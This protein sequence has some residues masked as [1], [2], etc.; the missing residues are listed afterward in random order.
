MSADPVKEAKAKL[1][2]NK[3]RGFVIKQ[4]EE[5]FST[6][7]SG[8]SENYIKDPHSAAVDKHYQGFLRRHVGCAVA[9]DVRYKRLDDDFY[10]CFNS[11]QA[12]RFPNKLA[13]KLA[14]SYGERQAMLG[15]I[16]VVQLKPDL[17]VSRVCLGTIDELHRRL[18]TVD[19]KGDE[20]ENWYKDISRRHGTADEEGHIIYIPFRGA[21]GSGNG[22]GQILSV[23]CKG[24]QGIADECLELFRKGGATKKDFKEDS[25]DEEEE[26]GMDAELE[27]V[28]NAADAQMRETF[29]G[30]GMKLFYH[31]GGMNFVVV[32][33][34]R[35]SQAQKQ[36]GLNETAA[37]YVY[38]KF[39]LDAMLRLLSKLRG[40]VLIFKPRHWHLE[41]ECG[42]LSLDEG[43]HVP[44]LEA[45][46]RGL[47]EA[48]EEIQAVLAQQD[49]GTCLS[50][51]ANFKGY[52]DKLKRE[53]RSLA[54]REDWDL[55][56]PTKGSLKRASEKPLAHI[57]YL[58]NYI[59][60]MFALSVRNK[61]GLHFGTHP[62]NGKGT[63]TFAT[64]L[65][66]IYQ[67]PIFAHFERQV[68]DADSF[69]DE[70]LEPGMKWHFLKWDTRCGVSGGLASLDVLSDKLLKQGC[71]PVN[72]H[73]HEI[74]TFNPFAEI[75]ECNLDHILGKTERFAKDN[76]Y[77]RTNDGSGWNVNPDEKLQLASQF[78][79][80]LRKAK[81]WARYDRSAAVITCFHQGS[82]QWLLPLLN[83]K[84][85][86]Q[87]TPTL[88]VVLRPMRQVKA[89]KDFVYV[90]KTVLDLDMAL[91]QA[92][93]CGM[94]SQRW[95]VGCQHITDFEQVQKL[96]NEIPCVSPEVDRAVKAL[97]KA[98][99][100]Q[101]ANL[102][103][104]MPSFGAVEEIIDYMPHED[105]RARARQRDQSVGSEG[106][107][108]S[109]LSHRPASEAG[110]DERD[111]SAVRNRAEPS[112][113]IGNE[114]G[115]TTVGGRI[116]GKGNSKGNKN[117]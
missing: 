59:R 104:G 20:F 99:K 5:D 77:Q 85:G 35:Q 2:G 62:K 73:L 14:Y 65:L 117:F 83:P 1:A 105:G 69:W 43:E 91:K 110:N 53:L 97:A 86:P 93:I 57:P 39:G 87:Q 52:A 115:F 9:A 51:Y 60:F 26:P 11:S 78:K 111:W 71:E 79:E 42:V 88:A 19:E 37:R 44:F 3:I 45:G 102:M 114:D 58:D 113:T 89:D 18:Q 33:P 23:R 30:L 72:M 84:S 112:S 36:G 49:M 41:S 56:L 94:L 25:D 64:G 61:E 32:D 66:D 107:R 98:Y 63:L 116:R 108:F 67:Q 13:T 29:N 12:V 10:L 54:Q 90:V 24:W 81:L 27:E 17:M 22:S 50:R 96:I 47:P 92:R 75:E 101:K 6:F 46:H 82:Y 40:D 7:L 48:E 28:N 76:E 80:S 109:V 8:V 38:N 70:P 15:S 4:D 95:T 74:K 55:R 31:T 34:G 103:M 100:K 16:A 68:A 106:S 21:G